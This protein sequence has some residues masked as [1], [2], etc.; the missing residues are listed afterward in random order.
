MKIIISPAKKMV[1]DDGLAWKALPVFLEQAEELKETI[2]R[3]PYEEAKALWKCNDQIA[4]LNYERFAQMEL[5]QNLTPAILSYEGIQYRYMAPGVFTQD[6]L[7]YIQGHLFIL[8]G[9]YGVL[10]PFDGI[11]PYR[12][13]MQ[14]KLSAPDYTDLY[15]FWGDRLCRKVLEEDRV[16]L[17]LASQEYARC[18]WPF[19]K[20][21]DRFVTC[22]F[23]EQKN[24]KIIQK[25]TLA[26]MARGE[27]VRFLAERNAQQP[28]D[29]MAF[30]R[31]GFRYHEELSR[32]KEFVFLKEEIGAERL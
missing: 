29:A 14:A 3:L 31:L 20:P 27:M 2:Q 4:K 21:E 6:C 18:I 10:R 22:V 15:Q 5:R 8:S 28:E 32:D 16:I 12:L 7:D 9:F 17:N 1:T 23:G 26:K 19:L 25:G 13:E 11:T 30:D 24:G